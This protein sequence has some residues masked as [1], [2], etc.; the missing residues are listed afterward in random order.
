MPEVDK[1]LHLNNGSG[2]ERDFIALHAEGDQLGAAVHDKLNL[3]VRQF[4]V[5]DVQGAQSREGH[6]H[7]GRQ[8]IDIFVPVPLLELVC[9]WQYP[10]AAFRV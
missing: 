6:Q 4:V 1:H 9:A 8:N 2:D 5:A 3:R 10:V 7:L